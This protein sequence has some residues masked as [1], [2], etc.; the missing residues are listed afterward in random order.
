MSKI[1]K[2]ILSLVTVELL[3]IL[4][5]FYVTKRFS[6]PKTCDCQHIGQKLTAN[7]NYSKIDCYKSPTTIPHISFNGTKKVI[8]LKVVDLWIKNPTNEKP[9][10]PFYNLLEDRYILNY[11]DKPDFV[12]YSA[13]G[14][15]HLKY[16]NCVK[17]YLT[18]ESN[19]PNFNKCDYA[20]SY[21][22]I[23]FGDRHFRYVSYMYTDMLFGPWEYHPITNRNMTKRRFCSFIYSDHNQ[24]LDGVVL[25]EKFFKLLDK[26]KPI[27][28]P[29]KVFNN[30]K[31][32][33]AP[34][35]KGMKNVEQWRLNKLNFIK[36][37]KFVIAFENSNSDGYTTEK[38][39]DA[40]RMHTIPIYFGNPKVSLDYNPKA[41]INVNDYK[42][43]E[44]VVEKVIEL[45]NDDDAYMAMLNEPPFVGMKHRSVDELKD[46]FVNIIEK[47]NKPFDK[48]PRGYG[49]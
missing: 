33:T 4:F 1:F 2:N 19:T 40:L 42:S 12:L 21:N 38:L 26:Y 17:I 14:K 47:G 13:W 6:S 44:E 45:D 29:G 25:H 27:D 24:K 22:P 35:P 36:D 20:V 28:S 16:N 11:S 43:L 7:N 49:E 3:V 37:R 9:W 34:K 32:A 31:M 23:S 48:D 18:G 5:S 46:F 8:Q 39:P 30:I 10:W 41:F 15:E